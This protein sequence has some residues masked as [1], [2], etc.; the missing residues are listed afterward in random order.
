ML[1]SFSFEEEGTRGRM[2]NRPFAEVLPDCRGV[3][4]IFDIE[5]KDVCQHVLLDAGP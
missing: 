5:A 4:Q 1:K 2:R 3:V